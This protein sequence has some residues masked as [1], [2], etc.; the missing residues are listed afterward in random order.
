MIERMTTTLITGANKGLGHEAA[1]RLLEAG[2]DVWVAARDEARGRAAADALGARFVALDVADDA[3]VAAAVATVEQ[4]GTGL[5]VLVNNAGISGGFRPLAE[6]TAADVATVLETNVLG[7]VRVTQAFLGLLERSD[8]PRIV[9]VSSGLGSLRVTNDPDRMESRLL[10]LA[11]PTSK[12]AVNM[13]TSQYAKNLPAMRVNAVDPGY[14]ATDLNGHRGTQ[15][16]A[17]GTD[18]IVAMATLDAD[19]PTGTFADRG[20]VVPW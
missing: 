16:V 11:Y 12:A 18:A 6:T 20:G 5:D 10:G 7:I 1:R 8:A 19:G 4:A 17:E 14:T 15:T 13:L 3:S 2:H 9:N